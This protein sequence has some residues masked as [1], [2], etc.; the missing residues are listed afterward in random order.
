MKLSFLG[1]GALW[2]AAI[3][4]ILY[5]GIYTAQRWRDPDYMDGAVGNLAATLVGVIV[6]IPVGLQIDHWAQA[7]AERRKREEQARRGREVAGLICSELTW[8]RSKLEEYSNSKSGLYPSITKVSVW[9][10]LKVSGE[11]RWLDAPTL[12]AEIADCY[13]W[14]HI[15][16]QL[17]R[18]AY[19]IGFDYNPRHASGSR[20]DDATREI[21]RSYCASVIE[22]LTAVIPKIVQRY[23]PFAASDFLPADL[24]KPLE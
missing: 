24:P 12:L 21:A 6:G 22:R 4:V 18:D 9:D 16:G 13:G 10:A 17:N 19:T 11:I 20:L 8:N 3:A 2:S 14:L 1:Y 23:G 5:A 15:A 7:H